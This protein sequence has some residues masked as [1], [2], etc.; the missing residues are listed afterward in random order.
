MKIRLLALCAALAPLVLAAAPALV[1]ADDAPATHQVALR[2]RWKAGEVVTVTSKEQFVQNVVKVVDGKPVEATE[3]GF[4]KKETNTDYVAIVK[5]VEA[6]ADGYATKQLVHFVKF[7]RKEGEKANTS[8]QGLQVRIDGKLAARTV[9]VVTPEKKLDDETVQWLDKNFGKQQRVDKFLA[10]LEPKD[11]QAVGAS[12]KV[13]GQELA[14]A[15]DDGTV[16]L[17]PSKMGAGVTLKGVEGD[18]AGYEIEVVVALKGLPVGGGQVLPWKDGGKGKVTLKFAR[19][20]AADGA[21]S[22]V[23]SDNEMDGIVATPEAEIHLAFKGH[24]M[25]TIEKGGEMPEVA[26]AK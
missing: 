18:H 15:M 26:P 5:C 4:G 21:E 19:G 16:P 8:L 1:R 20:L 14:D 7:E 11:P 25:T 12:W 2:M 13:G 9:T 10:T 3:P 6:D 17:E 22:A 23:E 24:E